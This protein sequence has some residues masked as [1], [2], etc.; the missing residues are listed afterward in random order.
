MVVLVSDVQ[1]SDLVR[2]THTSILFSVFSYVGY[3]RLLSAIQQVFYQTLNL[4]INCFNFLSSFFGYLSQYSVTSMV[5]IFQCLHFAS[6]LP[7]SLLE[8]YLQAITAKLLWSILNVLCCY[9]ILLWYYVF[10]MGKIFS[11]YSLQMLQ[12]EG[13]LSQFFMSSLCLSFFLQEFLVH[14]F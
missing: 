3:Y 6:W 5:L 2:H 12:F 9:I 14:L 7:K 10:I 1:Q 11:L 13:F 8:I 4:S